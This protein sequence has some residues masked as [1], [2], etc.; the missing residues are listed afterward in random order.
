VPSVVRA[1]WKRQNL[2]PESSWA[3]GF[4]TPSAAGSAAGSRFSSRSIGHL[5]FT[6]TSFWMDLEREVLVIL[7]TNRVHPTRTNDRIKLFRPVFHDVVMDC[8]YARS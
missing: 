4:D 1:F 8:L 3:L 2:V 5:G 6:G 7:L